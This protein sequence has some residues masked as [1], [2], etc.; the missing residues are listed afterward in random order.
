MQHLRALKSPSPCVSGRW[1]VAV[2]KVRGGLRLGEREQLE[3][4]GDIVP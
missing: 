4:E 1:F 3:E 2:I